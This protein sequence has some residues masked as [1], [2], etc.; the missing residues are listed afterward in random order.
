MENKKAG[1]WP[2]ILA[3]ASFEAY[4]KE[5]QRIGIPEDL[6]EEWTAGRA[7]VF[8]SLHKGGELRGCIGT[9]SPTTNSI[10]EEI[11]MN[12]VSA[13]VRDPRFS[14][15]RSEELPDIICSVDA[16]SPAEDISTIAELD[17]KK[18]GVIVSSGGRRGLLLPNLEGVDAVEDQIDIARRKAG[19]GRGEPYILQRFE[20]VRYE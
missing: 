7:G 2:V 8:V 13:A 11:I 16:L 14:P 3:R 6:P 12:A 18:Y 9:I 20:V 4:V 15:V 17:V 10:A 5:G 19:I 1:S